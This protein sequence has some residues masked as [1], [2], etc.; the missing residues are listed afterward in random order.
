MTHT[1]RREIN[2]QAVIFGGSTMSRNDWHYNGTVLGKYMIMNDY[3]S[4]VI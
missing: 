1:E 4:R 3:H 2:A